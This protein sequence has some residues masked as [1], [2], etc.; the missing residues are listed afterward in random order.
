MQL[1]KNP[2]ECN[3][4]CKNTQQRKKVQKKEEN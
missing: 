4:V 2:K 1:L 3:E